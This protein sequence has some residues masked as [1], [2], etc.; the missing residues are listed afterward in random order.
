MIKI[1]YIKLLD[2]IILIIVLFITIFLSVFLFSKNYDSRNFV[3][4]VDG[5]EYVYSLDKDANYR[6]KDNVVIR[7]EKG[8][9]FFVTSNCSN[10]NC[11]KSGYL[12]FK[13]S[14]ISCL[15]E[16]VYIKLIPQKGEEEKE[17]DSESF[18]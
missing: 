7:V 15:P 8:K 16:K 4:G 10:K 1:N 14:F 18:W 12:S 17:V 6:V 3:I 13:N 5:K 9:A 11:I 2:V